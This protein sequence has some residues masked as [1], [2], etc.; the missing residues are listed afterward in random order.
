MNTIVW[1]AVK[2]KTISK[3]MS[4]YAGYQ[5]GTVGEVASHGGKL[6]LVEKSHIPHLYM[7]YDVGWL[8]KSANGEAGLTVGGGFTYGVTK[9]MSLVLYGMAMDRGD[10][11][12]FAIYGG[13]GVDDLWKLAGDIID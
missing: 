9:Y 10:E 2:G 8:N 3:T 6:I 7:L 12:G 4:L 5:Y 11:F 1:G 13:I